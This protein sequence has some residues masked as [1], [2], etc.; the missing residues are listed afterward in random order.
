MTQDEFKVFQESLLAETLRLATEYQVKAEVI[1]KAVNYHKKNFETYI[2]TYDD[3]SRCIAYALRYGLKTSYQTWLNLKDVQDF[4]KFER[5]MVLG[6]GCSFE[7]LVMLKFLKGKNSHFD[8]T[9]VD[10]YAD[11]WKMFVPLH[12]TMA[13]QLG[14]NLKI[15]YVKSQDLIN[16]ID[17]QKFKPE[18]L[19]ASNM[20]NELSKKEI[21]DLQIPFDR[22]P[23]FVQDLYSGRIQWLVRNVKKTRLEP[24]PKIE[25]PPDLR[26]LNLHQNLEGPHLCYQMDGLVELELARAVT[27]NSIL[28]KR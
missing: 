7:L 14:I 10:K 1:E 21:I 24:F 17:D 23:Y 5:I 25:V 12:K 22:L 19:I 20:F 13:S 26:H 11:H 6:G 8:V 15:K 16:K 18:L 2:S 3:P 9:I 28:R 4:R 27:R